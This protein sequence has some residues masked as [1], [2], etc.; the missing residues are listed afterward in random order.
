MLRTWFSHPSHE[1]LHELVE[2]LSGCTRHGV[3]LAHRRIE[4]RG[5]FYSSN[6][7]SCNCSRGRK[8]LFAGGGNLIACRLQVF[9]S[10]SNLLHSSGRLI[11]LRLQLFEIFF[12][13]DDLP[14]K[15]IIFQELFDILKL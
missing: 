12:R 14:L 7:K 6:A 13:F 4:I 15:S 3:Y 8:E 1:P 2:I 11:G 9:T 10:S 5:C